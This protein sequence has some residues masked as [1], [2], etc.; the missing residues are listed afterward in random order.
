LKAGSPAKAEEDRSMTAT[1]A[2]TMPLLEEYLRTR[3]DPIINTVKQLTDRV[4]KARKLVKRER[5]RYKWDDKENQGFYSHQGITKPP[6]DPAQVHVIICALDY[7]GTSAP[8]TCTA[9]GDAMQE[10]CRACGVTD[11]TILYNR[12]ATAD[13]AASKIKRIGSRCKSGDYLVFFYAGHG[14]NVVD[15]DGDE[16]DGKDE[17]FCFVTPDGKLFGGWMTDDQF[18]HHITSSVA[19]DVHVLVV[20]DCCHSGTICDFDSRHSQW[21]NIQA[22]SLSGCRDFQTSGDT[23]QGG[24]F[25]HSLLI[26]LQ[27]FVEE[28]FHGEGKHVSL[29]RLFQ[30]VLDKDDTI[31][32]SAQ[33]ITM[34][35]TKHVDLRFFSWPLVPKPGYVAPW[36]G[37]RK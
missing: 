26:A 22:V 5:I 20:S 12:Q 31:F 17:A 35:A 30:R 34:N 18:A 24:I 36:K 10:L 33:D 15:E 32:D 9:D 14:A 2:T 25:T 37:R 4:E 23:G 3:Y 28:G 11:V 19:D 13:A 27:E 21:G 7:V 8:L 1:I 6:I 16:E 29:K